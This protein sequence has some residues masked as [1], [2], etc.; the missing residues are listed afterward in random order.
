MGLNFLRKA[1][2]AIIRAL[3]SVLARATSILAHRSQLVARFA[4]LCVVYV[5]ANELAEQIK[6]GPN[7]LSSTS[8]L[9]SDTVGKHRELIDFYNQRKFWFM[10]KVDY[11][12]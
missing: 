2:I 12:V 7:Q 1:R 11:E 10:S 9:F 6:Y 4:A 8:S 5:E 3:W